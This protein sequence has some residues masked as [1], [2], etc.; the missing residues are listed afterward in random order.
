MNI[1]QSQIKGEPGT[2]YEDS[3]KGLFE[4]ANC[5]YSDNGYCK[6]STMMKLSKLPK[7]DKGYVKI[8]PHGC[9]SYVERKGSDISSILNKRK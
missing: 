5:E 6:Q 1:N 7:N 2:G 9:C 3:S 4:C 8:D